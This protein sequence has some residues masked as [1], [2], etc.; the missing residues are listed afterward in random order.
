NAQ[1]ELQNER[2]RLNLLLEL[3]GHLVA[4][5][6]LR[7]MLKFVSTSVRR[8]MRCDAVVVHL[9]DPATRR[10]QIFALDSS[11]D[12]QASKE[13]VLLTSSGCRRRFPGDV[14]KTGEPMLMEQAGAD[15]HC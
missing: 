8:A 3:N 6:T 11:T 14:Y 15:S 10:L 7:E 9:P 1:A 5:L 13:G 12:E 2:D 4:S